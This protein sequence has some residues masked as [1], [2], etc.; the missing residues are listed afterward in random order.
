MLQ[1]AIVLLLAHAL[2]DFVFQTDWIHRNKSALGVAALHALIVLA[3]TLVLSG[4]LALIPLTII[5]ASHFIID[6]LK[7]T[8]LPESLTAFALD[9]IAHVLIIAAVAMNFP[10]MFADGCWPD[11]AARYSG[12]PD[13]T[14]MIQAAAALAGFIIATRAGQFAIALFMVRFPRLSDPQSDDQSLERGGAAIGNFERALVFIF[15]MAG[16][17]EAIGFLIAAKSILRFNVSTDR[18]ASEYVIIG[19]LASFAWALLIALAAQ[20]ALASL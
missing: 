17:P 14:V 7:S 3:A 19:T 1:T 9:Q 6:Y 5:V 8:V 13:T 20:T 10:T 16:H 15:L 11:I 12:L 4:S 18:A 2:S